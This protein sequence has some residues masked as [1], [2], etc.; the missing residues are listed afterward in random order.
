MLQH[1]DLPACWLSLP[2]P[3]VAL[4]MVVYIN[5][6]AFWCQRGQYRPF[7]QNIV[8]V[9]FDFS[10]I[11]QWIGSGAY[12]ALLRTLSGLGWFF[13]QGQNNLKANVLN[14]VS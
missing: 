10:S 1:F 14:K 6:V 11:P 4:G 13:R 5:N 7:N 9:Y 12:F 3:V 2:N 8:V